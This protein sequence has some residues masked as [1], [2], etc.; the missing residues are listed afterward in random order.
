MIINSKEKIIPINDYDIIFCQAD[1]SYTKI[2]IEDD[3]NILVTK[4]IKEIEYSLPNYFLRIHNSFIINLKKVKHINKL[5]RRCYVVMSDNN[6]IYI[7][8]DKKELLI[9]KLYEI[10]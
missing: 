4:P 2:I 3:S 8:R 9:N 5:N 7:S 1:G 6:E 10:Y